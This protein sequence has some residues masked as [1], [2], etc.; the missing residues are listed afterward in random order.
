MNEFPAVMKCQIFMIKRGLRESVIISLMAKSGL[1]PGVIGNHMGTDGLQIRDLPDI[2]IHNK[3]A[4]CI[5]TPN[6]IIVRREL[7]KAGHQYFTF[8]TKSATRNLIS[9]LNRRLAHGETLNE[10]SP[11]IPP[12]D[13]DTVHGRRRSQKA[14]LPTQRIGDKIRRVLRPKFTWRAVRTTCVF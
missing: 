1:R 13:H 4:E 9:Y 2:A 5:R 7:S 3:I 14:F 12:N 6:R 10:D 8:S 11:V